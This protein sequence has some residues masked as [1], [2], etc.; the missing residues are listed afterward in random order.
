MATEIKPRYK[1]FF[2][3]QHN[4]YAIVALKNIWA[5]IPLCTDVFYTY[6]DFHWFKLPQQ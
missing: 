6:G 4:S 5:D 2:R 1:I 3:P